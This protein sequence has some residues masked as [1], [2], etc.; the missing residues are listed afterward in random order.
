MISSPC[1]TCERRNDPKDECLKDCK[2]LNDVQ[3]FHLVSAK[4]D[5]YSAIDCTEESRYQVASPSAALIGAF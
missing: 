4:K 3:G 2:I 5:C 1:K